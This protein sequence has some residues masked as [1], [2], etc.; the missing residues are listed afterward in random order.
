MT[1][2]GANPPEE[3]RY[4]RRLPEGERPPTPSTGEPQYGA[5]GPYQQPGQYGA[6]GTGQPVGPGYGQPGYGQPGYGAP[7]GAGPGQAGGHGSP[8]PYGAPAGYG[9]PGYG[10]GQAPSGPPPKRTGPV[11]M[12]V[13]SAILMIAAPIVG[14]VVGVANAVDS[15]GGLRDSVTIT[16]GGTVDLPANTERAV[17]FNRSVSAGAVDCDVTDPAGRPVPTSPAT[18]GF[19]DTAMGATFRTGDAGNYTVEC[20]LPS[21]VSSTLTVA[22]PI[23]A[24]DVAGAGV[25]VLVGLGVG[26]LAFVTLIIGIVWLVRVNR[27]IR[28]GQY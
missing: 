28:T 17:Y 16:N 8:T 7:G 14:I 3:P 6:S 2:D 25:A 11:V 22:P 24:S 4:G 13:V 19:D 5:Q 10:Y 9:A 20:D 23:V 15:V 26:F 18:L 12:I 27:R 1:T 21:D